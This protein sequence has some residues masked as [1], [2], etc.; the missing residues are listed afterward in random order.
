MASPNDDS[1]PLS[2]YTAVDSSEGD[3]TAA[4]SPIHGRPCAYRGA[5]QLPRELKEHCQIFLE[6]QLCKCPRTLPK[7]GIGPV[8]CLI[9]NRP[10]QSLAPSTFSPASWVPARHDLHPLASPLPSPHPAISPFSIRSSSTRSTQHAPRS[11][12]ILRCPPWP[13][14]TCAIFWLS[15]VPSMPICAQPF[16]SVPRYDGLAGLAAAG[17]H[18]PT[19]ATYPTQTLTEERML[20]KER[21]PTKAG[22]G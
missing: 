20:C 2:F 19:I 14:A 3:S 10:L 7:A 13:S 4:S 22:C 12:T 15:S 6:E 21:W 1:S 9:A 16:S 17:T 8:L 5:R 18:K 11:P